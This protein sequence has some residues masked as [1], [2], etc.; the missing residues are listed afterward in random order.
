MGAVKTWTINV[1]TDNL[2]GGYYPVAGADVFF[3]GCSARTSSAGTVM[4]ETDTPQSGAVISAHRIGYKPGFT[5]VRDP[6]T[7][8]WLPEATLFL[9]TT[10]EVAT[11]RRVSNVFPEFDSYLPGNYSNNLNWDNLINYTTHLN[12]YSII[13]PWDKPYMGNGDIANM[14]LSDFCTDSMYP[15]TASSAASYTHETMFWACEGTNTNYD[16]SIFNTGEIVSNY[17]VFSGE[18][19]T[20][21]GRF[22][23]PS[24]DFIIGL[25]CMYWRPRVNGGWGYANYIGGGGSTYKFRFNRSDGTYIDTDFYSANVNWSSSWTTIHSAITET[26]LF[27]LTPGEF[28]QVNIINDPVYFVMGQEPGTLTADYGFLLQVDVQDL[29]IRET[30]IDYWSCYARNFSQDNFKHYNGPFGPIYR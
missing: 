11:H 21:L 18:M 10:Y 1:A 9:D 22:R 16:N 2:M 19:L 12:T 28:V 4:I 3:L 26:R 23:A 13:D 6:N 8:N 24:N 15:G 27:N 25:P 20:Y 14:W 30:Y 17:N 5:Y 29:Y 7:R